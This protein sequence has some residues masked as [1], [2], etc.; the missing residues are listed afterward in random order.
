MFCSNCGK[1]IADAA[2]F[3]PVCGASTDVVISGPTNQP[4]QPAQQIPMPQ[5]AQQTPGQQ[6]SYQPTQFP[7]QSAAFAGQPAK[8]TGAGVNELDGPLVMV[9]GVLLILCALFNI[10]DMVR[11]HYFWGIVEM[12]TLIAAAVFCFVK[13]AWGAKAIAGAA[14]ADAIF[15]VFMALA[16]FV[17]A[18]RYIYDPIQYG[19][20]LFFSRIFFVA[21]VVMLLIAAFDVL[22]NRMVAPIAAAAIAAVNVLRIAFSSRFILMSGDGVY[23]FVVLITT[24]LFY[25]GYTLV[26][27]AY[28]QNRTAASKPTGMKL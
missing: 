15:S 7:A 23:Y 18:L 26:C 19:V 16:N 24:I 5:P 17:S 11:A 27:F 28:Q 4:Q 22:S 10:Y 9:G 13:P 3:C 20:S 8:A 2:K 25:V 21:F 14:A 6:T 1:Q 12:L